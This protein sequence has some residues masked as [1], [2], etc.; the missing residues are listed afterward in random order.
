MMLIYF[1]L[2]LF[3]LCKM[4][5]S[6]LLIFSCP[7]YLH[8]ASCKVHAHLAGI[9]KG[10]WIAAFWTLATWIPGQYMNN[11]NKQKYLSFWVLENFLQQTWRIPYHFC[12]YEPLTLSLV[13]SDIWTYKV[14]VL[15]P[16]QVLSSRTHP[17]MQMNAFGG[18]ILSGMR[19]QSE[20]V[21]HQ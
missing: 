8:A 7:I 10:Y 4:W 11:S 17:H 18:Y 6:L 1:M 15:C 19:I 16:I 9:K 5:L 20:Q 21:S 13:S 12:F 3:A 14:L 2:P